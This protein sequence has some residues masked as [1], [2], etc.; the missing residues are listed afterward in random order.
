MN[1]SGRYRRLP[2]VFGSVA[3]VFLL[4]KFF[5]SYVRF[6]GV[7]FG[8]DAGIY[9]FLFIKHAAGLPP[10][11]LTLMPEWAKAH[12]L[13]LFFFSSVAMKFGVPADW[14]IGWVWN[15]FPVVLAL[16]LARVVK[17]KYG[18]W[19]GVAVLF[20]A[21][22]SVVQYEGFLMMYWK[23]LAALLWCALSFDAY[24]RKSPLL[25]VYGML[26]IATH[27]QIGLIYGAAIISAL[28]SEALFHGV[29]AP[30]SK[31][32]I[33]LLSVVLGL[34]WYLPNYHRAIGD[35]LPLLL[36]TNILAGAVV[37]MV[38]VASGVLLFLSARTTRQIGSH[39]FLGI[40]VGVPLLL[41]PL[42]GSA[43]RLLQRLADIGGQGTPG[44]FLS[45]HEYLFW[46]LPLL[47]LGL[48]GLVLSLKREKGGPWQWAALW[49]GV[50][51]ISLFFFYRRFILPLDFFLLPFAAH[52]A[53]AII[54]SKNKL[55]QVLLAALVVVQAG[56]LA[57]RMRTIDPNVTAAALDEFRM[58]PAYAEKGST[59]IVLD[60]FAPWVLGMAPDSWVSGPGIFDSR[61]LSDW[62]T[63]LFGTEEQRRAFISYYPKHTFFYA[64]DLFR[65]FYPAEVQT[66]LDHPCFI[67]TGAR[68]LFRSTC[69]R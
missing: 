10:F 9:R 19:H 17:R 38:L 41:S 43:P 12:P 67:P 53:V 27:Q 1:H 16:V 61:P 14:L 20:L 22:L 8:Y 48:A 65:S 7:P 24:E 26:T 44:V 62:E 45:V 18:P 55:L 68:G 6:P 39:I 5:W 23:V 60:T 46:S 15:V 31:A 52:A 30:I 42:V 54:A 66:L 47:A 56:M 33:F 58:L 36:K 63:F 29:K 64:T 37:A 4:C 32:G 28:L 25:V 49:S 51:V 59:I 69:G 21:F 3:V 11:F 50:A 13:G 40:L 2:L 34:A 35:V 57:D